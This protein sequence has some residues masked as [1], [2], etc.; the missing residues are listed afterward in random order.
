[1][2]TIKTPEGDHF[3]NKTPRTVFNTITIPENDFEEEDQSPLV[4]LLK[5]QN[6][7]EGLD[8][9][10]IKAMDLIDNFMQI[11]N[12]LDS[13]VKLSGVAEHSGHCA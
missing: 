2:D 7:L 6:K 8:A 5:S 13:L 1:M 12:H 10:K 9:Q 3:T 11:E 4:E